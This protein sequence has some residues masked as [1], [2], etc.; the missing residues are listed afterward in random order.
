MEGTGAHEHDLHDD[1]GGRADR[2]QDRVRRRAALPQSVSPADREERADA[3]MH[4]PGEP[5]GRRPLR[6]RR[7]ARCLGSGKPL[8][9][10]DRQRAA[11]LFHGSRAALLQAPQARPLRLF[12][13]AGAAP[14]GTDLLRWHHGDLEDH[15]SQ[16]AAQAPRTGREDPRRPARRARGRG[17]QGATGQRPPLLDPR[18][19][20]H[21]ILDR[22]PGTAARPAGETHG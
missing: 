9:A 20:R 17:A 6:G 10:A 5:L 13:Q 12:H 18:G 15:R 1:Q 3:G 8:P 7:R 14:G 22:H 16:P 11:A 21:R 19:T 2:L 4:R